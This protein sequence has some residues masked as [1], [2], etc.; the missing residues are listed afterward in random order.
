[1]KFNLLLRDAGLDPADVKLVRHQD[2]RVPPERMPYQLWRN[3]VEDKQPG[4][5]CQARFLAER[6]YPRERRL[7]LPHPS[8]RNACGTG[9]PVGG[10]EHLF[11]RPWRG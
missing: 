7:V 9:K 2:R 3:E 11:A 6:E 1:M 10:R 8:A 4:A 5:F